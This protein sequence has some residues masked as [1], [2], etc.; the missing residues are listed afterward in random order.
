MYENDDLGV[1]I[2][3]IWI[4]AALAATKNIILQELNLSVFGLSLS[5][6]KLI[7]Y[8]HFKGHKVIMELFW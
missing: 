4:V 8:R 2:W 5:T 7:F 3:L 1:Y 6:C